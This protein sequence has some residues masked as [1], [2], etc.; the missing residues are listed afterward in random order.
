MP[1]IEENLNCFCPVVGETVRIKTT[2]FAA[3]GDSC[4][5]S[6]D[7]WFM[8]CSLMVSCRILWEMPQ[9]CICTAL[10]KSMK[11]EGEEA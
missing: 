8:E 7:P 5:L 9:N 6:A 4:Q 3:G 2:F 1:F 11:V 10:V